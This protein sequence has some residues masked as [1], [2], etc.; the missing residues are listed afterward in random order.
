MHVFSSCTQNLDGLCKTRKSN[1]LYPT[2][3]ST[4]VTCR[5][6]DT[7][8]GHLQQS[9]RPAP[10]ALSQN[11][12]TFNIWSER[13]IDGTKV[14]DPVF[15][16][17][18]NFWTINLYPSSARSLFTQY[19]R[20]FLHYYNLLPS[21]LIER[22]VYN[23]IAGA[24]RMKDFQDKANIFNLKSQNVHFFVSNCMK[25]LQVFAWSLSHAF[26][27]IVNDRNYKMMHFCRR[28]TTEMCFGRC[29]A[30][31]HRMYSAEHFQP[32]IIDEQEQLHPAGQHLCSINT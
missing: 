16:D 10:F 13:S 28:Q 4:V 32:E 8:K 21:S 30:R 1:A 22:W 23:D 17:R 2:Y 31:Q 3:W 20:T 14:T 19:S 7:Q 6:F 26:A 5:R 15:D 9:S 24:M 11:L 29:T 27:F 18:S 12:W 25:L